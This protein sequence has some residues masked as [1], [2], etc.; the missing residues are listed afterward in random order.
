M[1]LPV[2]KKARVIWPYKGEVLVSQKNF[3][4]LEKSISHLIIFAM[5]T[6]LSDAESCEE[7]DATP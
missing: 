2:H 5:K 3:C 6:M 1:N 7:H 4:H